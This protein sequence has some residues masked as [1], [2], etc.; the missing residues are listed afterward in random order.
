MEIKRVKFKHWKKDTVLVEYGE[1]VP[2]NESSDR[3]VIRTAEGE[4]V[5]I[6]KDTIVEIKDV[7]A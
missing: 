5:D 7:D 4:F 3:I 6:I 2:M 1:I